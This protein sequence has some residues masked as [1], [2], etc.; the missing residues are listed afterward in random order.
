MSG[1]VKIPEVNVPSTSLETRQ[2]LEAKSKAELIDLL[3][4]ARSASLDYI[5]QERHQ[6]RRRLEEALESLDDAFVLYDAEGNLVFANSK[7]GDLYPFNKPNL[8]PGVSF[9]RLYRNEV[10]AGLHPDVS[11]D[12]EEFITKRVAD[13]FAGELTAIRQHSSGRWTLVTDRKTPTGEIVGLRTDITNLKNREEEAVRAEQKLLDAI[14]SIA[15]GFVLFDGQERLQ[16][17]NTKFLD[18]YPALANQDLI[19]VKFGEPADMI[20]DKQGVVVKDG[21]RDAWHA[22]RLEQFRTT[23]G[24]FQMLLSDG[25]WVQVGARRTQTGGTVVIQT[26]ITAVV[27]AE[28]AAQLAQEAAEVANSS[29][30]AFLGNMSHELRTPLNAIIGFSSILTGQMFGPI[31]NAKYLDYAGDINRSGEHLLKLINDLL[32][33]SRIEAGEVTIDKVELSVAE[34]AH[35]CFTMVRSQADAAGV[36]LVEQVE[37]SG[38]VIFA[39]DR[40]F[41]QILLNLLSNAIKFTASGGSVTI[42]AQPDAD[43]VDMVMITVGDT[44]IGIP[45]GDLARVLEPFGQVEG[46]KGQNPDGTGLGLPIVKS[47]VEMHGGSLDLASEVGKGTT[48]TIRIP[49]NKP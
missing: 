31:E 12:D 34:I 28:K 5:E 46:T 9:E 48:V 33:I 36:T 47:L 10:E 22:Q 21:D 4:N 26:D 11:P 29:K 3:L 16:L 38:L 32:D 41:R 49:V 20:L 30:T 27:M 45:P 24:T 23:E 14:E 1:K 43:H 7:F 6:H 25:R 17:C 19:G 42:A 35:S 40:Q 8:I 39:D 44:G 13:F 15:D 37:Q 2:E 18:F